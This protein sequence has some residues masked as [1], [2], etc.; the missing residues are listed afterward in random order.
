M[1][2][3]N[4]REQSRRNAQGQPINWERIR[5]VEKPAPKPSI[6][7]QPRNHNDYLTTNLGRALVLNQL[8]NQSAFEPF[9]R[10]L[11]DREPPF[12][13]VRWRA[14]GMIY[15]EGRLLGS[16]MKLRSNDGA[17]G[18]YQSPEHNVTR[19]V[20]SLIDQH[21]LLAASATRP[22]EHVAVQHVMLRSWG[23][24]MVRLQ[25]VLGDVPTN[26]YPNGELLTG[27]RVA[28]LS[29]LGIR[30]VANQA[31]PTMLE[32][33]HEITLAAAETNQRSLMFSLLEN[34]ENTLPE[35]I[36]LDVSATPKRKNHHSIKE[37]RS[38]SNKFN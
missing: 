8:T 32:Q 12:K 7:T 3:K 31:P 2:R 10:A 36:Q 19:L 9:L 17:K 28:V 20:Q 29:G 30:S 6:K 21:K 37:T 5:S 14:N 27:E 25:A 33:K 26:E 11:Q 4:R 13:I 22:I 23:K 34:V 15:A 38:T 1:G 18:H 24:Y 16:L 35:F